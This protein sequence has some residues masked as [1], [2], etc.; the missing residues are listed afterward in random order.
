MHDYEIIVI[1]SGPG[2]KTA[3]IQAA[4]LGRKV[5]IID[6][7]AQIG[8]ACVHTGTLPSKTLR[9]TVMNL[10]GYRE[11]GFYGQSYRARSTIRAEDLLQRMSM[12]LQNEVDVLED[13]LLRNNVQII[14]GFAH[15]IDDHHIS[16]AQSNGEHIKLSAARFIIAV[17]TR[18]YRPE[19][20]PFNGST[21]IDSDEVTRIQRVPKTLTIIGAGVIGIEYATIFQTLDVDVTIVEQRE[22]MLDFMDKEVLMHFQNDITNAGLCL[23]FGQA[24]ENVELRDDG[25]AVV[26]LASGRRI[27][28]ELVLF[29]AGRQGNTTKLALENIALDADKRGRITVNDFFQTQKPHIYAVGDVIG[30]PALASTALEQGRIAALHA[31]G[32]PSHKSP[33]FFPYGIYSVPAMSTVGMT[34]QEVIERK[35][36]YE[37]GIAMLRETSR[38]KIMGLNSG[39]M[40]MLFSTKTR[41]LLGVHIVGEGA[42]ELIHIGQAVLSFKGTLDYFLEN[43]FNYPT[44]AEAYKVAALHAN[45]RILAA[46]H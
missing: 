36:P 16:V 30:F 14:Q 24:V 2:G 19:H 29:A 26:S 13:Q 5:A 11:R 43:A 18:P 45:N 7:Q 35:I 38:G 15:F 32:E 9:E 44:L 41:R 40:K 20:I 10:T 31:F 28:S 22:S 17:G 1:G 3:A 8:G 42:T 6:G 46:A 39:M 34:E 21:V 25:R 4:K 37:V 23:Q 12:T 33:E 27:A